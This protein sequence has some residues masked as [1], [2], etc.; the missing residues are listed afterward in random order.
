[1]PGDILLGT[2]GKPFT[3]LEDLALV[4]GGSAPRSLR[5]EFLR[6]DYA[7]LRRVTA[8]LESPLPERSSVAA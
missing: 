8:R 2:E 1:M 6:G 4:L 3:A 5:L 7:K